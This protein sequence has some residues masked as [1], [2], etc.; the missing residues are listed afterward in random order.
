MAKTIMIVDDDQA[1]RYSLGRILRVDGHT[2]IEADG[3]KECMKE[4]SNLGGKVDLIL[5]DIMM[6]EQDGIGLFWDIKS[7][8]PDVKIIFLSA[9]VPDERAKYR[10]RREGHIPNIKKPFDVEEVRGIVKKTL[11]E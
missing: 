8:Y 5:L 10:L 2:I 6:P 11:G 4:L 3:Y 9:I 1:I 7:A